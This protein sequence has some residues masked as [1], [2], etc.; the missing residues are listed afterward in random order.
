MFSHL[1]GE[2]A[3][4]AQSQITQLFIT[5]AGALTLPQLGWRRVCLPLSVCSTCTC[6]CSI[7]SVRACVRR[8]PTEDELLTCHTT[9]QE[10]KE[11]R[12]EKEK[13]LS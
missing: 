4:S 13:E 7:R 6:L 12:G 10:R 8:P 1:C 11:A 2:I 3:I 9:Q 5:D